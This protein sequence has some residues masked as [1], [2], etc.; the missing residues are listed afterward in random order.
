MANQ[1]I[2]DTPEILKQLKSSD[3]VHRTYI[4]TTAGGYQRDLQAKLKCVLVTATLMHGPGCNLG[5]L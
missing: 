5:A 2:Q 4:F 3:P 1:V